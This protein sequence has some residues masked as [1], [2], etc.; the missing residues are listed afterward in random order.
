MA[1]PVIEETQAPELF[2]QQFRGERSHATRVIAESLSMYGLPTSPSWR[3]RDVYIAPVSKESFRSHIPAHTA[4]IAQTPYCPRCL[5]VAV[6]RAGDN[7]ARNASPDAVG[8]FP[9]SQMLAR[10]P[11]PDSHAGLACLPASAVYGTILIAPPHGVGTAPHRGR[12]AKA[13]RRSRVGMV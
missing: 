10:L 9:S 7:H 4:R 2:S 13:L 8:N 3:L 1:S 12:A 6:V 5:D 11:Q